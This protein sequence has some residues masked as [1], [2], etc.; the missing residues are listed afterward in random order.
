M[1]GYNGESDYSNLKEY[2]LHG[3]G[4]ESDAMVFHS[5]PIPLNIASNNDDN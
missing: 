3:I 1:Y 2:V 5:T 4:S